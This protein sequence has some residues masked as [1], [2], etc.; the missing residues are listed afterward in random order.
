MLLDYIM[1][2]YKQLD[3]LL[4]EDNNS[5]QEQID[6]IL[7]EL[8]EIKLILKKQDKTDYYKF[9]N[10]IRKELKADINNNIY[11]EILYKNKRYGID[12]KGFIYDKSTNIDLK[13][14]DAYEIYK[15]LYK[16]RK[17][18]SKYIKK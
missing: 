2:I 8:K 13:P 7:K 9:V 17:N 1:N 11:P 14:Q 16:N 18:L 15:F 12:F 4:Q 6:Q 3:N 10:R 5:C